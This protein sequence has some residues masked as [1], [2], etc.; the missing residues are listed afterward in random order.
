MSSS[1]TSIDHIPL[2][3]WWVLAGLTFAW[4]FNWTAMKLAL[5]EVA[6][7]TFRSM[8]LGVGSAVLFAV[9]KAGGHSLAVPKGQW[10]RL[11]GLALM[12]ITAWNLLVA[13]GVSMIPSGRAAILAYTMPAWAIPLSVWVLG[14]RLNGRRITGLLLGMAGLALLL[15]AG[16]HNLGSAPTGSLLVLCAAIMWALATV[17]Q[18]R[19]PVSMPVGVYTAWIMLLGGIPIFA[20]ALIFDDLSA[21]AEVSPKGW[22]GVSYNVFI[23]F[24][25]AHWAWIKL[26]TTLS[27]TVFSLAML[28]TPMIGVLSGI[29]FLGERPTAMEYGAFA[30]VIA[31]LLTVA[32]PARK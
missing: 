20:G 13:Y 3:L 32:L 14:E 4:G 21:L 24:A 17:F 27:V 7:F 22:F 11:I 25:W 5:T 9:M 30:L 16:V 19:F 2:R 10:G 15:G 1:A 12:A 8:C 29:L 23:A 18:K 31:S 6:P 26:A 28:L